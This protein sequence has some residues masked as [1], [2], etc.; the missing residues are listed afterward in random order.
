MICFLKINPLSKS[1]HGYS[2][3]HMHKIK[4]HKCIEQIESKNKEEK[5]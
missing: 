5:K 2:T 4:K 3:K 1:E